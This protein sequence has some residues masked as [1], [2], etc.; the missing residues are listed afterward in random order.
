MPRGSVGLYEGR[1]GHG[2]TLCSWARVARWLSRVLQCRKTSFCWGGM[3]FGEGST[4]ALRLYVPSGWDG[5]AS[6]GS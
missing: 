3:P 5:A 6:A 2:M 1:T 4:A